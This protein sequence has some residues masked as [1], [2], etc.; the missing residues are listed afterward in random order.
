MR[1]LYILLIFPPIFISSGCSNHRTEDASHSKYS[2]SIRTENQSPDY[3][4]K[5]EWQ[6]FCYPEDNELVE[7]CPVYYYVSNDT[8][9]TSEKYYYINYLWSSDKDTIMTS[10]AQVFFDRNQEPNEAGWYA[11]CVVDKNPLYDHTGTHLSA[12]ILRAYDGPLHPSEGLSNA[13]AYLYNATKEIARS[14]D[15]NVLSPELKKLIPYIK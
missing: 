4:E 8:L 1:L 14:S 6:M 2:D 11:N 7:V 3:S 5:Y 15:R 13:D 12:I 10:S 9:Y